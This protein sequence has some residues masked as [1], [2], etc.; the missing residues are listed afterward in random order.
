V[1]FAVDDIEA[2]A[3]HLRTLG[4]E[5]LVPPEDRGIGWFATLVD[6]DGNYVQLIQ[7]KPEYYAQK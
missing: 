6:P 4:V 2:A 3:A 5:W 7:M 1:N